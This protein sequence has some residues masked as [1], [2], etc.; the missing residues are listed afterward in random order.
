M[1]LDFIRRAAASFIKK[2]SRDTEAV[3]RM[4]GSCSSLGHR[5]YVA[6]ATATTSQ[7]K[8]GQTLLVRFEGDNIE[9]I[10]KLI[11]VACIDE[12]PYDLK[13]RLGEIGGYTTC[14]VQQIN[15]ISET[16]DVLLH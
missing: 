13:D 5:V 1:G 10:D 4:G 15:P 14:T 11:V 12:P 7:V 16:L 2:V 6:S 8:Q 9:L 3:A